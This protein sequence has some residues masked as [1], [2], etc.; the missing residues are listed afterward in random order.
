MNEVDTTGGGNTKQAY[1]SI[2]IE[3]KI[4][5]HYFKAPVTVK[6][7]SNSE[8]VSPREEEALASITIAPTFNIRECVKTNVLIGSV[9]EDVTKSNL[10]ETVGIGNAVSPSNAY[11]LDIAAGGNHL[12]MDSGGA[13]S[14]GEVIFDGIRSVN[15]FTLA[16]NELGLFVIN[17]T[18][19]ND[20]TATQYTA[21]LSRVDRNVLSDV[22]NPPIGGIGGDSSEYDFNTFATDSG[23]YRLE[24]TADGKIKIHNSNSS[25]GQQ[26]G[27]YLRKII[28]IM[29]YKKKIKMIAHLYF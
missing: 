24:C 10:Y 23:G 27:C 16:D 7:I 5:S 14:F 15:D 12:K 9:K 3:E 18:T 17:F 25:E 8:P 11:P 19:S 6:L 22:V 20:M 28:K 29:N 4:L 1:G 13:L 2:V 21:I 26:P